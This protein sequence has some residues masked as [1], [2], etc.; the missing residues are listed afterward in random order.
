MKTRRP[1]PKA[2]PDAIARREA[3]IAEHRDAMLSNAIVMLRRSNADF[4]ANVTVELQ[5]LGAA[6]TAPVEH[7]AKM[8]SK[9][10]AGV[11]FCP[12]HRWL[13]KRLQDGVKAGLN[14]DNAGDLTYWLARHGIIRGFRKDLGF[15]PVDVIGK[16]L[17]AGFWWHGHYYID[18]VIAIAAKRNRIVKA[19]AELQEVLDA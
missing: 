6:L 12:D 10:N 17:N 14:L 13:W 19:A 5:A 16:A 2:D 9:A 11:F 1:K 3:A 8:L 18:R 4:P 15:S 7:A